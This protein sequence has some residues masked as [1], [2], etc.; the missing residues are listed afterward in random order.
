M[1]K[2][3]SVPRYFANGGDRNGFSIARGARGNDNIGSEYSRDWHR[4]ADLVATPRISGIALFPLCSLSEKE[5][6]DSLGGTLP[7]LTYDE[8][9]K[10]AD[11]I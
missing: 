1:R 10:T 5:V 2:A 3:V 7:S 9:K 6:V 8:K 4:S 11:D